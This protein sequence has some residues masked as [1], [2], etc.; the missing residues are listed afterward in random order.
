MIARLRQIDFSSLK[1]ILFFGLIVRLV[2]AFFSE[3]YGM[4]DDHYLVIEA[5]GSWVDGQD[6]NHWLPWTAD[7]TGVPEG[8]S[9]TYVGFNFLLLGFL[10]MIGIADP[11]MMML[12]NRLIHALF[13]LLVIKYGYRITEKLSDKKTAVIAGWMLAMLW[14]MPFL[15]VRNLVEVVSMPFLIWAV[16][17]TIRDNKKSTFFYAG[18][19]LGVAISLR[20]QI[21]IYAVGMGIWFLIKWEWQKLL[22]FTAGAAFTFVLTQGLVDYCIWGYPFAE[23]TSYV[24][25]NM[26]EGVGY[27][28]NTNYFMYFYVLFGLLLFPLG[29]LALIGY[30]KSARKYMIIFL[31]TFLF[32]L[33]HSIFPNRQERFIL[34]ILPLVIILAL[35]GIRELRQRVFWNKFWRISWIAFWVLN[36][37]ML[38]I[39]STTTSKKSRLNTMYALYGHSK[40]N[41]HILIE[42]TGET[43]PEMMPFFY[44]GGW[45]F[46]FA[47]R[48]KEDT[49][50]LQTY[51]NYPHDF[52]FFFGEKDLDK[53]ISE[54]KKIYPKMTKEK[55]I[56]PSLIDKTLHKINPRNSNS[57]VEIWRTHQ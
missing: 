17:L 26:N 7:N 42:A 9:F 8:H 27:M 43:N 54:F 49:T 31:P 52:V 51:L 50:S 3:G 15:S 10:K 57:Y 40:G 37:P 5:A 33:F 47:E 35:L 36:I 48:R 53:R 41:E 30:F 24:I 20:Y 23:F 28:T 29:I 45:K 22:L 1:T 44:A 25:Y 56:E 13:S 32:L 55:E 14:A 6:Y 39:V 46:Q 34:T 12:I 4:H 38:M 2:A 16:W 18:I 21:A 11:K 19:L